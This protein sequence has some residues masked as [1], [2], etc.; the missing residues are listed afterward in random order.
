MRLERRGT[1]GV[2]VKRF[3]QR[4]P[5]GRV[6]DA[7]RA[8][9][10]YELLAHLSSSGVSVPRPLGL[11]RRGRAWEVEIEWIDGARSL[12][13]LC[14]EKTRLRGGLARSL[15]VLLAGLHS[16]RV[17]HPDLH[18]GNVLITSTGRVVGVDFDKA[19][20]VREIGD[21]QIDRDLV[22][23][24]AGLREATLP[25][26]RASALEAWWQALSPDLRARLTRPDA[27]GIELRARERR[28]RVVEA[29]ARRWTRA[30]SAVQPF[31][32]GRGFARVGADPERIAR[33][34]SGKDTSQSLLCVHGSS[35]RVLSLWRAMARL[36]E[37]DIAA[38]RCWLLCTRPSSAWFEIQSPRRPTSPH[39][40]GRWLAGLLDRGL[41]SDGLGSESIDDTGLVQP[42]VLSRLATGG[43]R[44][45]R[46][47][48]NSR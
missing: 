43:A 12:A 21:T 10:E 27:Q 38:P 17:D 40:R 32:S 13:D 47:G 31:E 24:C 46:H 15:G 6:L 11:A 28:L 22:S 8:R 1:A 4:G 20:L 36:E 25:R 48:R 5:L 14:R 44:E 37:H 39:G 23:L 41:W 45:G 30:G 19:R 42:R 26:W 18:A 35:R 33:A 7:A 34:L 3:E 16:N 29:R 9:R 2:I